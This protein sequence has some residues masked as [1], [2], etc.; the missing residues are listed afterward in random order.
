MKRKEGILFI[1]LALVVLGAGC[2]DKEQKGDNQ[3]LFVSGQ[4]SPTS[5]DP[6]ISG[7]VPQRLGYVETLVGVDY[8]GKIIPNLA[9]SWEVSSDGKNGH[10]N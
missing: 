2:T 3:T 4:W 6:H 7:T 1:L 8:E 5:I 9:K 10:S